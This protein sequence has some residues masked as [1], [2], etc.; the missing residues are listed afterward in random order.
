MFSFNH[1]V[2]P[3]RLLIRREVPL[4]VGFGWLLFNGWMLKLDAEFKESGN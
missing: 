2:I 3:M 4:R 1:L